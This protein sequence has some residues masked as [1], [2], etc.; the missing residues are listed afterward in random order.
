MQFRK[1]GH[2]FK[3]LQN[4]SRKRELGILHVNEDELYDS[5]KGLNL[6]TH[7]ILEAFG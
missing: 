4:Y 7:E 1:K 5:D 2:N 6:Q 3:G